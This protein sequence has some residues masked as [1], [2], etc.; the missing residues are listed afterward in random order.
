MRNVAVSDSEALL[1][2]QSIAQIPH[3]IHVRRSHEGGEHLVWTINDALILRLPVDQSNTE[4]LLREKRL[5]D[6]IRQDE[7]IAHLIPLCTDIGTWEPAGWTYALYNKASGVSMES[8]P[9]GVT[10]CTEDDLVE[11]LVGLERVSVEKAL[12]LGIPRVE[13]ADVESLAR[14]AMRAL[15]KLQ[16][17]NQL[18][19]LHG[20][21]TADGLTAPS[22]IDIEKNT[23]DV[24]THADLKGEHI[25]LDSTG[26][27]TGI[28]DW[29]D[30]QVG[31]PSFEVCGLTVS[32]GA[33]MAARIA[34]RGGHEA[35]VVWKGVLMARC[36][37]VLCLEGILNGDDD[38][39]ERLVRGQ[40]MRAFEGLEC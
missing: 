38:S 10:V 2:I 16:A 36:N 30:A 17:R 25:F 29:S 20:I 4:P 26:R 1:F 8:N 14:S 32:V 33:E 27:V 24:L 12:E 13:E 39:P 6:F 23:R 9:K 3:P 28:I 19:E 5:L 18:N 35:G 15:R 7:K 21:I 31:C 37:G 22:H 40:L 34:K 11:F